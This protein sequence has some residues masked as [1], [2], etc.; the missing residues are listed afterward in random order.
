MAEHLH[1]LTTDPALRQ[2]MGVA[3]RQRVVE[4]YALP[5]VNE[6]LIALYKR[7]M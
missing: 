6:Q 1:L 4:H 7:S 5:V 3:G 2:E